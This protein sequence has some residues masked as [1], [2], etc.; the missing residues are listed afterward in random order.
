MSSKKART[1]ARLTKKEYETLAEFR[2][3]LR[4]F[5]RFSEESAE[6]IGVT[7]Q[8]HQALLAIKGFPGRERITIGELAE[9]LQVRP[10]SALGLANRLISHDLVRRQT[11]EDDRRQ[12]YI[13]LTARGA[14]VLE[15]LAAVHKEELRRIAP[16][17]QAFIKNL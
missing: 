8:H 15:Q 7:P 16:Q 9:R 4:Q 6:R 14:E 12:V 17:L 11:A 13:E 1:S 3:M 2:H 5:L 10:H